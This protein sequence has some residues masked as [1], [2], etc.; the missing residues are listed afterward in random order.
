MDQLNF[1]LIDS[2]TKTIQVES[3]VKV[4]FILMSL[5][6]SF[7][8]QAIKTKNLFKLFGEL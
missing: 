1:R 4:R 6:K 8:D 3:S 5:K 7:F 2:A